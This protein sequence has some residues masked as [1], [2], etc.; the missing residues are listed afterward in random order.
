MVI[1][2]GGGQYRIFIMND[3]GMS[4]FKDILVTFVDVEPEEA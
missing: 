2:L 4:V 3:E 1:D